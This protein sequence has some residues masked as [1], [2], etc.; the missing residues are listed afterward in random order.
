M[1]DIAHSFIFNVS[2]F[3]N[4]TRALSWVCALVLNKVA[5]KLIEL[6]FWRMAKNLKPDPLIGHPDRF[7][8]AKEWMWPM[9]FKFESR[10]GEFEKSS[11]VKRGQLAKR[12]NR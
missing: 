1:E 9:N 2:K 10:I 7:R 5:D 12:L 11:V 4:L 6:R 3:S 8:W